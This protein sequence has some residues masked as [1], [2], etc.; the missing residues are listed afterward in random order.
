MILG[1]LCDETMR[2]EAILQVIQSVTVRGDRTLDI[3]SVAYDSRVVR[4]GSL[5]VALPGS[6]RNGLE[7]VDDAIRRGAV[8]IVSEERL[9]RR[10]AA[11]HIQVEDARRALAEIA[12]A[13][14]N[15]PSARLRMIGITGTNGKTTTAYMA[16][17]ILRAAGRRPGMIGTVVY[18]MGDRC[19]PAGRTTPEAPDV[20]AMLDQMLRNGCDSAVMEV[21]S[22]ALDQKRVWGV[23]FDV[24]VFTN[25]TRDH[26]DYHGTLE[27]Y[28]A[29]KTLLFRGLGQMEKRAAAVINIDDE[30]GQQLANIGGGWSAGFTYGFHPAADVRAENA[31]IGDD[32]AAFRLRTPWGDADA[33]L[34]T[35]GR[36]N[37]QNALAA[38]GACGALGVPVAD[39]VRALAAFTAAPGRLEPVSNARGVRVFVDYAHTDDALDNVLGMLRG[40]GGGRLIVVFGC[41][42][43]R[44]RGKRPR[45]GAAAAR[46]ADHVI[47]TSDN[48]RSEDPRRIIEEIAA[49]VPAGASCERIEDREAAIARAI[50]WARPGDTVLIAGK[51]HENYQEFDRT[52]IP[53]DDREVARR[54]LS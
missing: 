21:S 51:G 8:A 5:F 7:F 25:L 3:T 39:M 19:I 45:M 27:R 2:I 49:G 32:G 13:F 34:R 6:R 17:A 26:L 48:P 23:D 24:G 42:G 15:H 30:W 29:A 52:V 50:E 22:H 33:G 18:E 41:G 54:R 10:G 9:P 40:Q 36:F 12:C 20:Q 28:F 4:P 37:V 16:R 44:D 31:E 43:D 1:Q 46:W 35:L 11:T 53:F 47:L 38:V 14:Y